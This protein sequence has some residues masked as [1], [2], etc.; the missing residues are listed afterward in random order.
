[1]MMLKGRLLFDVTKADKQKHKSG[2]A[3]VSECLRRELRDLLGEQFVEVVW[4]DRK[5]TFVSSKRNEE[6]SIRQEDSLLTGELFCEY[7]REGIEEFI[8]SGNCYSYSIFHD[9]IPLQHPEFTWPHSVQRHPSYLKMLALFSGAFAVSSHSAILLEEYWEWLGISN[10]PSVKNL[11]LGADGVYSEP[12]K[13][14]ASSSGP[15]RVVILGILEKRKGQDIALNACK[16]L[17][18]QGFE[19]EAHFVGRTNPY[20][21]RE[22]ERSLKEAAKSGYNVIGHGQVADE[23]LQKILS[24]AHLTLFLSR[25]EGCGLPVLESLWNGIPVLCSDLHPMRENARFG[26]CQLTSLDSLEEIAVRLQSLVTNRER[27]KELANEIRINMLPRW[28]AT[29]QQIVDHIISEQG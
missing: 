4:S 20:F 13:S 8:L 26:G 3:R 22:I 11:Q 28:T 5:R 10:G 29:A 7:E 12:V 23:D 2:L 14:T 17:W 15:V 27:L 24:S 6:L 25:A 19:F 1:M 21:G 18:D 9:A 16:L